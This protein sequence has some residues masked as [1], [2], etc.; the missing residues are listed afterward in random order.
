MY[1]RCT[2]TCKVHVDV[3][4][5]VHEDVDIHVDVYVKVTCRCT[6]RLTFTVFVIYCLSK[7]HVFHWSFGAHFMTST[8]DAYLDE[9]IMCV[10]VDVRY[11]QMHI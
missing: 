7:L 8:V 3:H 6:C 1:C 11:M 2:C 10:H 5:D 4:A 9:H